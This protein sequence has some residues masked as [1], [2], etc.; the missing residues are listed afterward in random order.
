MVSDLD[1]DLELMS[2]PGD[3]SIESTYDDLAVT[4]AIQLS[5]STRI[6]SD[7]KGLYITRS[8]AMRLGTRVLMRIALLL[9]RSLHA[10][11]ISTDTLRDALSASSWFY[12]RIMLL[13]ISRRVRQR[14]NL[15]VRRSGFWFD[16]M[17]SGL[18]MDDWQD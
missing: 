2:R 3:I 9:G 13:G 14:L 4:C 7:T 10:R 16:C 8:L 5:T 1:V 12:I 17:L 18:R 6:L 11:T 15:R